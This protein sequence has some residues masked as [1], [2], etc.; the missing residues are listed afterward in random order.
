MHSSDSDSVAW[1]AIVSCKSYIKDSNST[2]YGKHFLRPASTH[3]QK[4][5]VS[6]SLINV[7]KNVLYSASVVLG[8]KNYLNF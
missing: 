3:F 8:V 6:E 7:S 5:P 2:Y 1:V 4:F